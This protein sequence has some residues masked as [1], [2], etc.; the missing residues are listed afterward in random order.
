MQEATGLECITAENAEIAKQQPGEGAM[1][2][3]QVCLQRSLW[4]RFL[5]QRAQRKAN[6]LLCTSGCLHLRRSI[7]FDLRLPGFFLC[8][9][10]ASVVM[11]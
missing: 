7:A 11:F 4:S 9:S 5:A 1:E 2:Q 10:V 3:S 6:P 8:S